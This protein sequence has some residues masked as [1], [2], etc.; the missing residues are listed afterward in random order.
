MISGSDRTFL[1]EKLPFWK[2]LS[3]TEMEQIIKNT[4]LVTY[5]A[6]SNVHGG[7]NNCTG[8]LVMKSGQ[9]RTYIL[10]DQGK[11]ITLYRLLSEDICILS[12]SCMLKN[13]NF[14][15]FV[16]AE[17]DS[18]LYLI[19]SS[20]YE[21]MKL[22]NI[23]IE[24]FTNEIVNSRFSDAM[25]AME[26]VLFMSF[27]KRLAIFLIDQAAMENTDTIT[28]TH[29]MIAKHVG[30]ARE[31]V[32]RM[33]K[34]FQGEGIVELSRKGIKILDKKKLRSFIQ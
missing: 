17:K 32:S 27:D 12:A 9:L 3:Q 26:Q 30:S 29:E 33:L 19:N 4:K 20:V 7:V 24:N 28:L 16:D 8:V 6:G 1:S 13:I 2:D 31:V 14:D 23:H 5:Q 10:S 11:E 15:I 25:W 34:Y 18:E 22:H 21:Y